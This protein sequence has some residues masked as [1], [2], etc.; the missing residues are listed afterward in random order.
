MDQM[1]RLM[2]TFEPSEGKEQMKMQVFLVE[3]LRSRE[4]FAQNISSLKLWHQAVQMKENMENTPE[5][6]HYLQCV[7][8][9]LV[10]QQRTSVNLSMRTY[11]AI[12]D[13]LKGL[14]KKLALS[15]TVHITRTVFSANARIPVPVE[16]RKYIY[17]YIFG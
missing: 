10:T 8:K 1:P 3:S 4:M 15:K 13:T 12:L 7:E 6:D 11:K 2:I 16:T 5:C 14:D 17:P 9:Y